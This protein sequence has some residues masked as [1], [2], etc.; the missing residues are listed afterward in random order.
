MTQG[1]GSTQTKERRRARAS[2]EQRFIQTASAI[3]VSVSNRGHPS[4]FAQRCNGSIMQ[5]SQ[6]RSASAIC[7]AG[8]QREESRGGKDSTRQ[9]CCSRTA[10]AL[11]TKYACSRRPAFAKHRD[12]NVAALWQR[13][14]KHDLLK[15]QPTIMIRRM[16]SQEIPASRHSKEFQS[17]QVERL[18]GV[19]PA[20][21]GS[22]HHSL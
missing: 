14:A 5:F 12:A 3:S 21:F 16:A 2:L 22:D 4:R 13:S 19:F 7:G 15:Q 11:L 1:D 6:N 17:G 18:A 10:S 20:H 8:D 9:G